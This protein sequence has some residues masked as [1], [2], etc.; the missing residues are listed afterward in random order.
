MP[1]EKTNQITPEH[2]AVLGIAQLFFTLGRFGRGDS[3][4]DEAWDSVI[5]CFNHIKQ[6]VESAPEGKAAEAAKAA[7]G[8]CSEMINPHRQGG[9][10]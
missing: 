1:D 5:P 4:L 2:L 3:D 7:V 6:A 10:N 9:V 8:E